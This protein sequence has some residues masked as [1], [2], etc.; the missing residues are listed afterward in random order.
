MNN[1]GASDKLVE[2][3]SILR[4]WA[5]IASS[6]D[7]LAA[8]ARTSCGGDAVYYSLQHVTNTL[9]Q[10]Q[11]EIEGAPPAKSAGAG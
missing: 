11:Q 3:V 9:C 8:I 4:G 5:A 7:G 6:N 1:I 10:I 2:V